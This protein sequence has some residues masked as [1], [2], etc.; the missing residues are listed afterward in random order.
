MNLELRKKWLLQQ[1]EL[2]GNSLYIEQLNNKKSNLAE[3]KTEKND[4]ITNCLNCS[5]GSQGTNLIFGIG[6]PDADFVFI[7]E[8]SSKVESLE[9]KNL[10]DAEKLFENII[11][12]ISLKKGDIYQIYVLQC[13]NDNS[14]FKQCYSFLKSKLKSINPKLIIGLGKKTSQL[15]PNVNFSMDEMRKKIF[16][17]EGIDFRITYHPDELLENS[18]LKRPVWEDFKNIKANYL[19]GSKS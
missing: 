19:V 4:F 9:N 7:S 14:H 15:I 5:M 3:S 17:F 13:I 18:N 2:Y 12:A 6:N 8:T 16:K 1:K 11:S 10:N